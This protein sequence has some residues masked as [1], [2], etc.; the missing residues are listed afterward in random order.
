M[1]IM[2]CVSPTSNV[3]SKIGC[4]SGPRVARGD[5]ESIVEILQNADGSG[6]RLCR[7]VQNDDS[8]GHRRLS[9]M[10]VY[11]S[12]WDSPLARMFAEH[13]P[14]AARRRRKR[15]ERGLG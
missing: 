7:L 9:R 12:L 3:P 13:D 6:S 4:H 8:H 14:A 2:I 10:T 5:R 1:K 15:R 11:S